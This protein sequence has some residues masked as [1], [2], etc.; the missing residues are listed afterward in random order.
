MNLVF[1][2]QFSFLIFQ[3]IEALFKIDGCHSISAAGTINKM[4][5]IVLILFYIAGCYG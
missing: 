3:F 4:N 5:M 2:D 1:T